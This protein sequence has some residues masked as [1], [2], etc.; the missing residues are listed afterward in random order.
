MA[1]WLYRNQ[2][3]PKN[4][5]LLSLQP[6][7]IVLKSRFDSFYLFCYFLTLMTESKL[8]ELFWYKKSTNKQSP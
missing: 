6:I 4:I 3:A 5:L 2:I 1:N 8:T 7:P